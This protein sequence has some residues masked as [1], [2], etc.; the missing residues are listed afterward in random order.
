MSSI[1]ESTFGTVAKFYRSEVYT[2]AKI[3]VTAIGIWLLSAG[4]LLLYIVFGPSDG[5]P[6]GLGLL[7]MLGTG[8]AM[9]LGG[10]GALW[11]LFELFT[12]KG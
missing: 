10:I 12:R 2:G 9:P 5:N 7:A 8:V 6:I 3:I 11:F 1:I 4:P